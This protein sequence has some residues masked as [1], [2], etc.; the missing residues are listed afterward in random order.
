MAA[1]VIP[2]QSSALHVAVGVI[3]NCD[4]KILISKRNKS[5][6]QGNLWEFPGGKVEPGESVRDA[7]FRELREELGIQVSHATPLIK[8][9]HSYPDLNVLLDV[10][11]VASFDGQPK[12]LEG[13]E[14]AWVE[15]DRLTL[16]KFPS[17]NLPILTAVRL[18]NFYAILDDERGD[19]T[20]LRD[21]FARLI[22]YGLDF[23]RIRAKSL[24]Q[25]SYVDLATWACEYAVGSGAKII[26]NAEPELAIRL[27]AAGIHLD[28]ARLMELTVK[29]MTSP[30]WIAA[31]C[32]NKTELKQAEKLA[33]DFAVLG[34]VLDTPS[35]PGAC[36]LTWRGFENLVAD[37]RSPVYGI[38]GLRRSDLM[39]IQQAGGQGVAGISGFA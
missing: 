29:P 38:G 18:P 35:H 5:A 11:L 25:T 15:S 27:G 12:G 13:Q 20:V 24:S 21:R 33:V 19:Q 31:S 34:P 8:V 3:K 22:D 26:L 36:T 2:S 14:T 37:T 9:K 39:R 17:A 23:I 6:H 7:L 30:F 28:S 4:S 1:Q 10:W 16:Y 32:H